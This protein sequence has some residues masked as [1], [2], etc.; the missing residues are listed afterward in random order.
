MPGVDLFSNVIVC[1]EAIPLLQRPSA[2]SG[3]HRARSASLSYAGSGLYLTAVFL[4]KALWMMVPEPPSCMF[5]LLIS[6][7]P[8]YPPE[9]VRPPVAFEGSPQTGVV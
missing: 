6:P 1:Q 8:A 7:R 9:P 2:A 4:P 3:L 5:L